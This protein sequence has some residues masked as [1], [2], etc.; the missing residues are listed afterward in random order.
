MCSTREGVDVKTKKLAVTTALR[1]MCAR[2]RA[3]R[4]TKRRGI[5]DT[6][7]QYTGRQTVS[8]N[9]SKNVLTAASSLTTLPHKLLLL[10]HPKCG[11]KLKII[12][13]RKGG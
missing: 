1:C 8:E 3:T 12:P 4:C 9:S 13:R 10:S 7:L 6:R 2:D 11:G 5:P